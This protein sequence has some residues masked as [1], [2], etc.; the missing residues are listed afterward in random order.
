MSR[1][2]WKASAIVFIS[3]FCV[4]VIELIASRILAPFIGVSLYTWT[5]I[6]GV[7]LFGI[8]LG[9]F[10]GGK[11]A[12]KFPNPSYLAIIFLLGGISTLG[13]LPLIK[14]SVLST[15]FNQLPVIL[16]FMLKTACIFLI[17]AV[18]LSMVT[19]LVIRL[20]LS[21]TEKTGGVVG[22]I[23]AFSTAGSILGTFMTGFYLI[24][25]FGTRS[26]VWMVAGILILVG[27]LTWF[28]WKIP[29]KWKVSAANLAIW[30][31]LFM[32]IVGSFH[33]FLN[34]YL[35]EDD[36]TLESNYYSITV[37]SQDLENRNQ[38]TLVLDHLIH[39]LVYPDEPTHL[40]Y[41]YEKIFS[42]ITHYVV[43]EHPA[44]RVLHLGGGGYS[45]SRYMATVYPESVNEVIEVDPE[46][47]RIAYSEMGL[48]PDISIKTFNQDARLFL[49]QRKLPEKY[50]IVVGDVFNDVSVPFHLTT[51]EFNLLVKANLTSDGIY[52]VNIIDD[53]KKGRY[54][55]SFIHT[56]KRTFQHVTLFSQLEHQDY[57][58][59][60][61]FV[62]AASDRKID[63]GEYLSQIRQSGVSNPTA[64]PTADAALDQYLAEKDPI[65]LID[66][67]V[68]TDI[69]LAPVIWQ[70]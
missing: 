26:I 3:S 49:I 8:A 56:L 14:L 65:L 24:L 31:M 51:L 15:W 41:D 20:T 33:L 40:E 29:L 60:S 70:R 22:T 67:H 16:T 17:P 28:A 64:F 59:T 12:D 50:D 53:Y 13:I 61:T 48:K 58:G 37:I 47:T 21:N 35:W 57:S 30:I 25:W 23:Y 54:L 68:P 69:L 36:Y 39:S 63:S 2:L 62:I 18:I 45:F 66:D 11:L 5:S 10:L 1:G 7:I 6:I 32:L 34:R 46:I 52:M 19:P 27:V 43:R 42:E 38:K 4:M 44:P 9:N 55:P